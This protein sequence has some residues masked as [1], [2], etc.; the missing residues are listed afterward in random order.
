M[1]RALG[2]V[3]LIILI[4]GLFAL[5]TVWQ[6]GA[7]KTIPNEFT[8]TVRK[9]EGFP[10]VEDIT[11]DRSTGIAF[12]SSDDRW[13]T[14]L[15]K[16]HVKGSIYRLNLNDSLPLPVL[17]TADF[18]QEDFHPHGISLF[19]LPGGQKI[20]FVVN[21]R[22][23]G[24]TIERFEYRN[25]SLLHRE[26]ISDDL[27]VS[28]NDVVGVGEREFY[29][30][31]DHNEKNS[32]LRRIKDLLTIGTGNVCYYDGSLVKVTSVQD[33]KYANG[34]NVSPDGRKIYVAAS[35]ARSILV[36]DRDPSTGALTKSEEIF[37]NTGVDNIELD[38]AGNL[39]VGCH[40]Q[41]LKFLAHAGDEKVN[42]P[43]EI[44]KLTLLRNGKFEQHTIYMNDGS[45]ISASS[46]GAVYK[47]TLLIGAV[48]Q[49]HFLVTRMK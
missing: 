22:N 7:F 3:F 15:R 35:S 10:G 11:I 36:C 25:D 19:R 31:N 30:T 42:S 18:S 32:T 46:V 14:I 39:W 24:S 2:F 26:S 1:K 29:F 34:V 21:H 47:N 41:L 17:L 6:S 49:R 4:I 27:I 40:P 20:L 8:G 33:V 37:T 44:I 43:S 38:S 12:L 9:I 45:E 48:F 16:Q 23:S 5:K 28:P 13:A